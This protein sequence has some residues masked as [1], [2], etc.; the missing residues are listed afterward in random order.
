MALFW[1]G[2]IVEIIIFLVSTVYYKKRKQWFSLVILVADLLAIVTT[3]FQKYEEFPWTT[4]I[5][6]F[7]Q[8]DYSAS[9]YNEGKYYGGWE[10]EYPQGKGRLTY[11]HFIDNKFYSINYEGTAYKA[12]YYDGEFDKGWRSGQGTVVYEG[13]FKDEGTFYG[14]WITGKTVFIGKRWLQNDQYNC[15]AELELVATGSTTAND[16]Y[17]TGW[18]DVPR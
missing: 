5:Y 11:N 14:E 7:A 6:R 17:I 16:N 10:D 15:Y 2:L 9:G 1:T 12:E 3:Y 18:I 13:G 8:I 4:Y